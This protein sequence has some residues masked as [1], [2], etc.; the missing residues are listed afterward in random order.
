MLYS[1][2]QHWFD[3]GREAAI[4]FSIIEISSTDDAKSYHDR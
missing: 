2:P 4:H 3:R 1:Y